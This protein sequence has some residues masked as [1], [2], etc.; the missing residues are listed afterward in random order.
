MRAAEQRRR[1]GEQA[2]ERLLGRLC[3]LRGLCCL[4]VRGTTLTTLPAA[5]T[6]ALALAA[7]VR[8]TVAITVA[9]AVAMTVARFVQLAVTL[10][11]R[12]A[13]AAPPLRPWPWP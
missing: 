5:L 3:H 6:V 7:C 13:L 11:L 8:L 10:T 4:R 2:V 1:L 12:L 9:V